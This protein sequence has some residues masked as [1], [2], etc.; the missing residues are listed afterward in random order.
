MRLGRTVAAAGALCAMLLAAGCGTDDGGGKT[1]TAGTANG[2]SG[3]STTPSAPPQIAPYL[4]RPGVDLSASPTWAKAR[5][6]GHLIVGAKDDQPFLGYEDPATLRRSGFDIEIAR[7]VSAELGLDPEAVEFRT[8]ASGSR[9]AAIANGD[10]DMY[11][12]TYSITDKRKET[13]D[14]AGPYYISGQSLLVRRQEA[15]ITGKD[16]IRG[17]KVCAVKGSTAL[18]KLQTDFPETQALFYDSYSTCVEH[19]LTG[20]V[21]AVSTDEAILKGYAAKDPGHLKI[22]GQPFTTENYGIGLPKGDRVLRNAVD[23]ALEARERDGTW[24]RAYDA[25][26][27]LSGEPAPAVPAVRRD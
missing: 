6:R 8:I 20:G 15:A 19:L 25:T 21:D 17:K 18:L 16:T 12:G 4:A 2:P 14:F 5:D 9:E 27:G 13:V 10:V 23:D 3:V 24:R 11:V 1:G 22:V 7:M 26:L